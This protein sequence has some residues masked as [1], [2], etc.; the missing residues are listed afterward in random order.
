M[1]KGH[2]FNQ[3]GSIIIFGGIGTFLNFGILTLLN[4]ALFES[5]EIFTSLNYFFYK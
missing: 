3:I 2:F 1:K 5:Q 4:Y